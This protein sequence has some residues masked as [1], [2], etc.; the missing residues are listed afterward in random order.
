MCSILP[1]RSKYTSK[2]LTT[3]F[4]PFLQVHEDVRTD[5]HAAAGQLMRYW[6]VQDWNVAKGNARDVEVRRQATI[7]EK[8]SVTCPLGIHAMP[9]LLS[10]C[11]YA[12]LLSAYFAASWCVSSPCSEPHLF[13]CAR[14]RLLTRLPSLSADRLLLR[15]LRASPAAQ[16]HAAVPASLRVLPHSVGRHAVQQAPDGGGAGRVHTGETVV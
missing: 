9:H 7:P 4:V 6:M 2:S 16:A 10:T 15:H 13:P 1:F 14:A 11:C 12:A 5:D 8:S 3:R